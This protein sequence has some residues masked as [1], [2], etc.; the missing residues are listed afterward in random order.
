MQ[1]DAGDL[2]IMIT[3]ENYRWEIPAE[4]ARFNGPLTPE[5]MMAVED[6]YVC[7]VAAGTYYPHVGLARRILS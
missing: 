4:K 7:G 3:G 2:M 6:A 1:A 5:E